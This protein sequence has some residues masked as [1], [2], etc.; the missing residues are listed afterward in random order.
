MIR[1][2]KKL[3]GAAV[4]CLYLALVLAAVDYLFFY[5]PYVKELRAHKIGQLSMV[6]DPRLLEMARVE[7]VDP[8]T[9]KLLGKVDADKVSRF[10]HFEKAKADGVIRICS[11]GDSFA[12]GDEVDTAHDYPTL[13][14]KLFDRAGARNVEVINFAV[15]GY[16]FHQS[17]IMW[18]RVARDFDCDFNLLGPRGF[19]PLRDTTFGHIYHW[20]PYYLHTRYVLHEGDV[21]LMEILGDTYGERFDRHFRFLPPWRYLRYDRK[22]PMFLRSLIPR[23]RMLR[24]PFYYDRRGVAEEAYDT[25]RILLAKMAREGNPI[26]IGHHRQEIVDIARDVGARN[27]SAAHFH[28]LAT[29]PYLAGGHAGPMGNQFLARQFF[30]QLTGQTEGRLTFL[31]TRDIESGGMTNDAWAKRALSE[32]SKVEI[33]L[34]GIAVGQFSLLDGVL[35]LD[36]DALLSISDGTESILDDCFLPLDFELRQGMEVVLRDEASGTTKDHLIGEV[37][38][39]SGGLNIGVVEADGFELMTYKE[40]ELMKDRGE[41]TPLT[42]GKRRFSRGLFFE[43][44]ERVDIAGL[45][46]GRITILIHGEAVL[47]GEMGELGDTPGIWL[48]PM[49]GQ[50]RYIRTTES[51]FVDVDELPESGLVHLVAD[52]WQDGVVN[53]PIAV[54][55]KS[56]LEMP[57]AENPLR[58][59][60]SITPGGTAVISDR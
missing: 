56:A 24:N 18:D 55:E 1:Y 11:F 32:Y 23:G 29:F 46:R 19:Q 35:P 8:S 50:F 9:M 15:G 37:S 7:H 31:E 40:L 28:D 17:Y 43:G 47:Q 45:S 6:D 3:G 60:L 20:T 39:I 16:G 14:Q 25:Y 52:H 2:L 42:H 59:T 22:A 58:K 12:F 26:L 54:W 48:T 30:A 10:S 5:R 36:T 34:A 13:L 33:E 27:L 4:Y 38:L 41:A 21:K 51:G 44:N 53:V 49:R 57:H